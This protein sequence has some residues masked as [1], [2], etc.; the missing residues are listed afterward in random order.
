MSARPEL[1]DDGF[2]PPSAVGAQCQLLRNPLPAN[3]GPGLTVIPDAIPEAVALEAFRLSSTRRLQERDRETWGT[4]LKLRGEHPENP[5][6]LDLEQRGAEPDVEAV[7][8]QILQAFWETSGSL[9]REDLRHVHGFSVWAVVGNR[10]TA[11][12]VDYAEVYRRGTNVLIPPVHAITLQV[13]PVSPEEVE[14]GTFGAHRG[15]LEHYRRFGY[16]AR[17]D[18]AKRTMKQQQPTSDWDVD[19]GWTFA[20]YRFRQATLCRG[21]LGRMHRRPCCAGRRGRLVSWWGSTRWASSRVP[22]R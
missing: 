18:T 4:Y 11:Y 22:R 9:L 1:F 16:K 3:L 20:P 7:A 13:S 2:E 21:D 6:Q 17:R 19:P 10:G 12:H 8:A 14:G 5:G 15:A